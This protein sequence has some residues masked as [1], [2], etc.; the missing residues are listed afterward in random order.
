MANDDPDQFSRKI[1]KRRS[2]IGKEKKEVGG[3]CG[4]RKREQSKVAS[5]LVR[6]VGGSTI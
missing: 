4:E 5:G 2:H 3:R 1:R 6:I